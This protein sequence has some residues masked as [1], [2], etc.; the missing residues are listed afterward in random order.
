MKFL[1]SVVSYFFQDRNARTNVVA[2]LRFVALLVIMILV[3]AVLFRVIMLQ[4]GRE[5]SLIRGVYWAVVTMTTLGYGDITFTSDTGHLFSVIVLLSGVVFLLVMLPFTFIR[6][7]YAPW[8]EAHNRA[9]TPRRLPEDT[10]GH[11]LIGGF[12]PLVANL[13]EKLTRFGLSY[14]VLVSDQEEALRLYDQGYQVILGDLDDINTYK[15]A[16]ADR[17]ALAFFDCNDQT[18]THAVFTLRELTR[19]TPVVSTADSPHS[20]D[21]LEMAG[22]NQVF[23]FSGM[24]GRALARR[25]LGISMH[26]N[27]IGRFSDLL[28]AEFPA[29]R[30]PLVGKS[31]AE[32]RV[33][34]TTGVNVV[35]VWERGSFYPASP[36]TLMSTHTVLVLAGSSEQLGRFGT[37]FAVRELS[38][39]PVLIIGGGS[40]GFAAAE[41]LRESGIDYCIVEKNSRVVRGDDR[42]VI[43]D[44]ADMST[45][46]RAGID[47]APSVMV[48]TKHDDLNIYLTIYCRS[49]RPDTQIISRATR[50][51]SVS[52]LHEAGA[53]LVMSYA[54]MG[55][56]AII[57]YVKGD[58]VLM[59]AEDLDVFRE[60]V[61]EPLHH[62]TLAQSEIRSRTRCSVVAIASAGEGTA[63]NPGPQ[64]ELQPTDELI[65]IGTSEAEKLFSRTFKEKH[66]VS[67]SSKN[68]RPGNSAP[69]AT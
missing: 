65:L 12:D 50:E 9:R 26:A 2:L 11:V 17:A 67:H 3:F 48:T 57:N 16:R 14:A 1:P 5:Y 41:T 58:D 43:G 35:G 8:L 6:F 36:T 30:T 60:R 33:R 23:Q 47:N 45:L 20:V 10:E 31:I 27:V 39:G 22:S 19:S 38:H 63:I 69:A 55:A 49:I 29:M 18:N 28:I 64:Y 25:V 40:E 42:V 56:N 51:R 59:I 61:P 24:L 13:I 34:E 32:S 62:R 21:I 15:N 4:E 37:V 66:P 52:K 7:F 44:A 54:S 68:Q 53:D 46:K